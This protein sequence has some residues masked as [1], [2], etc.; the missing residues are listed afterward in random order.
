VSADPTVTTTPTSPRFLT[1][2]LPDV[3]W[4]W[5]DVI[6]GIAA[7]FLTITLQIVAVAAF[8]LGPDDADAF[9]FAS[10]IVTY[11]ALVAVVVLASRRKGLRSLAADFGLRFRWIDLPLGLAA[12]LVAKIFTFVLTAVAVVLTNHTPEQGNFT[13]SEAPVW[14]LL[15]GILIASLLAPFV[16]ELFFRGLVLRAARHRVLRRG[17]SP[18][19]AAVVGILA[20][21]IGFAALHLLQSTDVT[22]LIILGGSTLVLGAIN[23]VVAIVTGRIGA[24]IIAHVFYNGSSILLAI[25]LSS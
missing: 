1:Y 5:W 20:S 14:V 23:S 18:V 25:L 13:L 11:A 17:G 22:L 6:Y 21:S 15:N 12:G 2:S 24:P 7:F 8:D 9:D 4:G 3:R 19:R 16:E 10:G